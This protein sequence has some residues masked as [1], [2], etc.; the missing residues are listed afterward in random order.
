MTDLIDSY[1]E[2]NQSLYYGIQRVHP[3][4]DAGR[5]SA[6]GQSFTM[7]STDHKI[8]SVK[9]YLKKY[10]S[11]TG[12]LVAVLYAHSGTYG[13][14]SKPTGAALATSDPIAASTLTTNYVLYTFTFSGAQQV[15][16][17][18]NAKYCIDIEGSSATF[19]NSNW[20]YVGEDYTSP[21]H[22]GNI[23]IYDSAGWTASSSEDCIFYVYGDPISAPVGGVLVQVM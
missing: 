10:G 21:T 5:L 3:S 15:T 2:S 1:A 9:F 12:N 7:L 19:D 11:P 23:F 13:T 14:S 4:T 20:V 6:V 18:A 16:M 8:T 22:S 17:T